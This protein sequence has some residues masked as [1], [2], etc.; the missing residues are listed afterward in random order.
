MDI[1]F[2]WLVPLLLYLSLGTIVDSLIASNISNRLL[3]VKVS[4]FFRTFV[5]PVIFA[6]IVISA[7]FS[8]ERIFDMMLVSAV[9]LITIVRIFAVRHQYLISCE[10]EDGIV[11][12]NFLT[13]LI[14][15]K[16]IQFNQKEIQDVEFGETS[17][18]K[19]LPS[20][21]WFVDF[22]GAMNIKYKHDWVG[23]E[24]LNRKLKDEVV[25][26]IIPSIM[27]KAVDQNDNESAGER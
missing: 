25:S 7:L 12:V 20:S 18:L 8:G 22:P 11:T 13:A 9:T 21:S 1:P 3:S 17:W 10:M 19:G 27:I 16:S 2:L 23:F 26:K 6:I 15:T 5:S 4:V 14:K 24:V